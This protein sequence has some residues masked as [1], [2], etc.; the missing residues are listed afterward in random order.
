VGLSMRKHL[1]ARPIVAAALHTQAVWAIRHGFTS[2]LLAG[3]H[4][5]PTVAQVLRLRVHLSGGVAMLKGATGP[6][7]VPT[8]EHGGET[9]VLTLA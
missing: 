2:K 7:V 3:R 6:Y 8:P 1:P 9:F 4:W 5:E